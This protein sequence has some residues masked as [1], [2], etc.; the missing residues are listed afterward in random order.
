M[1]EFIYQNLNSIK[2]LPGMLVLEYSEPDQGGT[3]LLHRFYIYENKKVEVKTGYLHDASLQKKR[4]SIR[5]VPQRVLKDALNWINQ[6][7]QCALSEGLQYLL[8]NFREI[9]SEVLVN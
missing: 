1:Q 5:D 8:I 7:L 6:Q 9:V 3:V 4:V 2:I